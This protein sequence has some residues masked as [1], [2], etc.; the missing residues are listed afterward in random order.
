MLKKKVGNMHVLKN[1]FK[2][3]K[4]AVKSGR[5]LIQFNS[6]ENPS[7]YNLCMLKLVNSKPLY[8]RGLQTGYY[9]NPDLM[10]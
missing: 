1:H 6:M 3:D 10:L 2:S 9:N 7:C 5:M 8:Q 4:K